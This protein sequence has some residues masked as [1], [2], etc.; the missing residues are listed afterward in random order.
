MPD[1]Q[2]DFTV[3]PQVS[4]LIESVAARQY[5]DLFARREWGWQHRF[6]VA[7]MVDGF[8]AAA[9]ANNASVGASG[10]RAR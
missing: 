7:E 4:S 3:D 5:E 2:L 8:L 1:A 9:H 10:E 6:G